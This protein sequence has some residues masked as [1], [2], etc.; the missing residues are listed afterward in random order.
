[1]D[2][3]SVAPYFTPTRRRLLWQGTA[4]LAAG[5][6][7]PAAA[8]AAPAG[9]APEKAVA[10]AAPT[11]RHGV[12][13]GRHPWDRRHVPARRVR[14]GHGHVPG[15]DADV[16]ATI[17]DLLQAG[18]DNDPARFSGASALVMRKGKV[19][20]RCARGWA[21][22]WK[23]GKEELPLAERTP[24]R[25]DTI[26]DLA[27]ISKIFTAVAVMQ[28]VEQGVVRLED[29]VASHLPDFAKNGKGATTV[30]HLLTHV[31]GLPPFINLYSEY[32]TVEERIQAV[33]T[34]KPKSPAGTEY[35]Y[36]DLG[37]I[38][39]G[40]IVEKH[41][42]KGLDEYVRENITEPLGMHETMY[43]PPKE[44]HS[45][46][47]ATEWQE[48]RGVVRGIVHDENAA[49]LGGVAGHAGVFS[50]LA[51][52]AI[53]SQMFL[54][55]GTYRG[56][57][58]LRAKTVQAM[59]TDH[60]AEITGHGG[61]RR[62]LGPELEAWFYHEGLTSPYSGGH[63]GFTG[64]SFVIDPLSDTVVIM[65][66]NSVHPTREWSTTSVVRR[67][68]STAVARA[69][70]LDPAFRT[71]RGW[72]PQREDETTATLSAAVDLGEGSDRAQ[73]E[74]DLHYHLET[75]SDVLTVECSSDGG[76][77]WAPLA[78]TLRRRG[79]AE[80]PVPDGAIS[81][82]GEREQWTGCFSLAG[83]SGEVQIRLRMA[84]DKSALGLGVLL[85]RLRVRD[86]RRTLLDSKRDEP[87]LEG[88]EQVG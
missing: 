75:A 72:A 15:L 69:L 60:I 80:V 21:V 57:R 87:V 40:L 35:V 88:W 78:G 84:T 9:D 2:A 39:L 7:L 67:H 30:K 13:R 12:P 77:T 11:A 1:M 38:T 46:I 19:A 51:D 42:G 25:T 18:I 27:S 54:N 36:S 53:F 79:G 47:A 17:P 48:G 58:V 31:G 4:A 23:N 83:K 59:F 10:G 33:L 71:G 26:Y 37:L 45:R 49:S 63:T 16:L 41:S 82:W 5:L 86:G 66:T 61:A 43:N 73:L 85:E 32:Q 55:G 44:L 28:L 64:T 20:H 22:H 56:A 76:T 62:G 3:Q 74:L 24:A 8:Q 29:T 65:L 68:V 70:G 14:E 6:A 34:V 50:T 52:L 81:G